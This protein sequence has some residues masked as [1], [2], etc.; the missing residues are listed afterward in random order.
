MAQPKSQPTVDFALP[1]RFGRLRSVRLEQEVGAPG[2]LDFVRTGG[3]WRLAIPQP[4]VDRMEY[5]FEVA[6]HNGRRTTLLDPGNPLRVGGAFGDK[7]VLE[8]PAYRPPSWLG[9]EPVPGADEE[10]PDGTLWTPEGLAADEP[11]PLFVVHD[12]PEYATLGGFTHYLGAAIATGALPPARAALL[13]PGDRNAEYSANP[14]YAQRLCAEVIPALPPAT[15]R[16]GIGVSLGALAMLHAHHTHPGTLDALFLQ[17]GS[18]F[19]AELD[20]QEAEF[21]GFAAVTGFVTGLPDA[22]PAPVPAVLTC[23]TVEENRANNE[24]MTATL[25]RLGYDA[26]FEVRRDAH[27][28][29]AWR[30][31]LNPHLTR[32]VARAVA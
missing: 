29:T 28:Y 7:S 4:D 22:P 5:L 13:G 21:S 12:G 25:Q 15:L 6:D 32:L 23:G 20:P 27:N 3:V 26:R 8:F 30:D 31:A 2:P 18:F 19:T 14:D 11:A 17:S 24:A 16:V 1:D 10:I 9:T